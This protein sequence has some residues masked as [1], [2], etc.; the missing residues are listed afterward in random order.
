M[1]QLRFSGAGFALASLLLVAVFGGWSGCATATGN[2]G[3]VNGTTTSSGPGGGGTGGGSVTCPGATLCGETCTNLTFDPANCGMCGKACAAGEVCSNG[4]CAATCSGGATECNGTCTNTGFDPNN[5]G[6][7]GKTCAAGEVCSAGQCANACLGGT[8]NCSSKCVDTTIDPLN[9]GSCGKACAMGEVCPAGQCATVCSG[10]ATK[11]GTSCVDT[12]ND[13]ANCGMCGKACPTGQVCTGGQCGTL[14]QANLTKCGSTCVDSKHDPL[15]CGACGHAC[16]PGEAC[17]NGTCGFCLTGFTQCNATCVDEQTDPK[18][19][20]GCN[21]VCATDQVCSAGMCASMCGPGLT[22]CNQKCLNLQTDVK[23]CGSCGHACAAG[24]SCTNGA[25]QACDSNTTDCD[26]DGWMV[27][28]GDCCDKPGLCGAQPELVNPGAIEVVGNGID[29]NCNGLTDLFDTQDTVSCD[30]MLTS[31]SMDP[32]DYAKAI[33]ICRQTQEAPALLKDKTWGL[34]DAK[35]LRADGSPLQDYQAIS[36]RQ[37]FGSIA[38]SSTEGKSVMVMSSGIAS[39][40]TQTMPG[41]NGGAPS[42]FNVSTSHM[43][44]SDVSISS[45]GSAHS[46]KDW[47][48]TPNPPLKA[49]NGLPNSPGCSSGSD[50][51]ANDSVMLYLRLRAPTNVKAFSFNSYFFSAEYPEYVCTTFNDQ[52]IALVDT[53]NGV[54]SPIANPIDKNLMTYTQGSKQWP[55]GINIAAGTSLFAVCDSQATNPMCWDTSVSPLS[56][57]LGSSQ[58]MGTGFEAPTGST[59]TIGGG[60]FWLTT[61]GNVIPGDIVE[62]RIA[63]WDVGD[64]AFDSLAVIDGFKWLANATLPG[65]GN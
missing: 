14:C 39:D 53:P 60:T 5:C 37:G 26:G 19:C 31:N 49:A 46:V 33:G 2:S 43:P 59:C 36:I 47:Y 20:G 28:D 8:T 17:V 52:F 65:T 7:C 25:C 16:A 56:C 12:D 15:N 57:S 13:P 30:A 51:T 11:C 1:K 61:A 22:A 45:G 50:P 6:S 58:L 34:I 32:L 24:E 55:I 27:A 38:P 40:A 35:I 42:G 48:A 62:L 44:L 29:D 54:P 10:G 4:N 63:I 9:C 23:N 64:S 21:V 41:P 3:T 18:N